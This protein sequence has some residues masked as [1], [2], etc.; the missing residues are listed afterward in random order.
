MLKA[1]DK[2]M[3]AL[4]GMKSGLMGDSAVRKRRV[5][6]KV[7]EL[8]KTGKRPKRCT[9]KHRF[10][11][12]SSVGE[13]KVPT[14]AAYKDDLLKAGLGEQTIEF[15]VLDA[16]PEEFRDFIYEKFPKLRQG[17]GYEFC[18]CLPNSRQL[19]PLSCSAYFSP[20][21]FKDRVGNT[22]T[23]IRPLQRDLSLEEILD[24]PEGVCD[25]TV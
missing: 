18:R 13:E 8:F 10:V 25:N 23:Y 3:K 22:R 24:L 20:S 14:S 19:E 15:E 7:S 11:C 1:A 16:G 2:A 4:K 21:L 5:K 6:T 17:G 12:L 9:W